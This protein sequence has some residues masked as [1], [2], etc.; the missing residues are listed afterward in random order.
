MPDPTFVT[1]LLALFASDEKA[2][3]IHGDLLEERQRRGLLWYCVQVKLT[4]MALAVESIRRQPVLALLAYALYELGL[5]LNWWVLRPLHHIIH[6]NA[7]LGAWQQA[8][9]SDLVKAGATFVFVLLVTQ[10]AR[11]RTG[12]VVLGAIALLLAR[13]ALLQGWMNAAALIPVVVPM[14]F[15]AML[16]LR[17]LQLRNAQQHMTL[18]P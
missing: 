1:T 7:A 2:E 3:E 18:Q 16:G 9:L 8:L 5:K 13:M 10:L 15:A 17:W 12:V 14:A 11:G 4:C 6:A